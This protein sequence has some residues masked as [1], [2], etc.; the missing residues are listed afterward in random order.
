MIREI[1]YFPTWALEKKVMADYYER[2]GC[3]LRLII[4]R[5]KN[6]FINAT[7]PEWLSLCEECEDVHSFD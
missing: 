2:Y 6:R 1:G 4:A 7:T 3:Y 5:I